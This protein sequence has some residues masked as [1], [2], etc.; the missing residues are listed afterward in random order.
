MR[1]SFNCENSYADP[2]L[3]ATPLPFPIA[4]KHYNPKV[5][6]KSFNDHLEMVR[7]ADETFD[8]V[9]VSEHHAWPVL[10]APN[11]AV[12]LGAYT[13]AVKKAKLA[14]LGPLVSMTNPI[15]I[16]E[17]VAMLDQM[18]DGRLVCLFLRG[19]P[20]EFV[21][22][23]VKAE[24]TRDRTQ[25]AIHLIQRSLTEP[26]PFSWQGRYFKYRTVSVWPGLTQKPMV[27]IYSSGNSLESATFAAENGHGLAISFFA[28][29]MV[30]KLVSFYKEECARCGWE[31]TPEQILYRAFAALGEDDDE[32]HDREARFYGGTHGLFQ[33]F[34]G[35]GRHMVNA[36][37]VPEP[38][39]RPDSNKK[40]TGVAGFALG[41]LAF[42][43]AADTVIQQVRAFAEFTGVGHF[44]LA[45]NGGGLTSEESFDCLRRFGEDVIPQLR[46]AD[47][48]AVERETASAVV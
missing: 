1:F 18:T 47:A 22:Y 36:L 48:S 16:A 23:G 37:K 3:F 15:R 28:A 11:A 4:Q 2:G 6:H 43:G 31:P 45:F 38:P 46:D 7:F 25:E 21:V 5:G 29:H 39:Q 41:G 24:E 10:Q 26:H 34:S 9:S 14:W 35:R 19:T 12:L 8:W 44:D 20:N 40:D 17:E 27:P 13:Q 32:A 42:K 30:E 33:T